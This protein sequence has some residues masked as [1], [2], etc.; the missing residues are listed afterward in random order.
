MEC[1]LN[2]TVKTNKGA[3]YSNNVTII[4]TPDIKK[5]KVVSTLEKYS[6][7]STGFRITKNGIVSQA[8]NLDYD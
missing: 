2:F 7:K 3:I 4:N 6:G 8:N 1:D 5:D